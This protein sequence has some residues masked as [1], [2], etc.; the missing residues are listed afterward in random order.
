MLKRIGALLFVLL[1]TVSVY[2]IA[3]NLH[4]CGKLLTSVNINSAAKDCSMLMD[5][6][7]KCCKDKHIEVKVKD[8]HQAQVWQYASAKVVIALPVKLLDSYVFEP[9]TA[10]TALRPNKAPPDPDLPGTPIFIQNCSF[11]I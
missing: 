1:Y 6:K 8:V 7:M 5:G 3:L 2:G 4:Y 10:F 11:R 9:Q